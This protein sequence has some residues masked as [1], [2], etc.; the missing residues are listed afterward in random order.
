M[1]ARAKS[2]APRFAG[3]PDPAYTLTRS[4]P[5]LGEPFFNTYPQRS[6]SSRAA[7]R[8]AAK[9]VMASVWSVPVRV[10]TMRGA[11]TEPSRRTASRGIPIP[12][13]TSGHTGTNST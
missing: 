4:M 7:V 1:R 2:P 11:F 12:D 3:I 8:R 5:Q 13:S 9:A 10:P 6:A